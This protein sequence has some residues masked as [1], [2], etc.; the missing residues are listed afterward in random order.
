MQRKRL[1]I[2][3]TT[4]GAL[5]AL[6]AALSAA[7]FAAG[8]LHLATSRN[9]TLNKTI[10]VNPAGR[11]LYTLSTETTHHL[12]CKSKECLNTWPPL[13]VLSRATKVSA[14]SGVHGKLG[15]I[16]RSNGSWQ[17]T[18]GGKPLYRFRA[19]TA[20][21]QA[22]GEGLELDGG[23]WHA[24]VASP[25]FVE[26]AG[27]DPDHADHA[28][29]TS[30]R[31]LRTRAAAGRLTATPRRRI[32]ATAGPRQWLRAGRIPIRRCPCNR[33]PETKLEDHP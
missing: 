3:A 33:Q 19:D 31:L 13:T 9:A 10:L 25:S 32:S 29:D 7:A 6:T 8:G 26:R 5:V 28:H 4:V 1:H 24:V 21:G 27:D 12:L 23:V 11:T 17:V 20:R 18:L 22:G 30:V 16:K 2:P 15:L 14:A